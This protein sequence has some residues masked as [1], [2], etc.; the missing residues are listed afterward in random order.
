MSV[1]RKIQK[2]IIIFLKRVK[3][4]LIKETKAIS[5]KY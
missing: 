1:N 4:K 2:N 5:I 3:N